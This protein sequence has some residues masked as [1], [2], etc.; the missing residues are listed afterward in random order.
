VEHASQNAPALVETKGIT[1]RIQ[2]AFAL[3]MK[4][5]RREIN[6]AHRE[7]RWQ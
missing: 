7:W 6:S 2:I 5:I 4:L 3:F 1:K